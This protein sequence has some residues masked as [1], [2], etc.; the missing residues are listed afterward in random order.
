MTMQ[1]SIIRGA[2]AFCSLPPACCRRLDVQVTWRIFEHPYATHATS[3]AALRQHAGENGQHARGPEPVC[4]L[5][6]I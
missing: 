3:P 5:R 2:R 4:L 6:M 1:T